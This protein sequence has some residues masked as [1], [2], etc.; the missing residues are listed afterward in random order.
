MQLDCN[1]FQVSTLEHSCRRR[2]SCAV[3]GDEIPGFRIHR[4]IARGGMGVV[5]EAID[6]KTSR[7]VALKIQSGAVDEMTRAR[8][9]REAKVLE[10]LSHPNVVR[11][12]A[13]GELDDGRPWLAMDLLEGET[14][15]ARVERRPCS[16]R[17]ATSWARQTLSALGAAHAAGIVHRDVKPENLFLASRT[18][19]SP[20]LKVIDF[21]IAKQMDHRLTA[22]GEALGSPAYMSPE[23]IA[24]SRSLDPRSDVWSMGVTMFELVTG[25]MPFQ[26]SNVAALLQRISTEPAP[27]ASTKRADVPAWP[28]DIIARCLE[29][30]PEDRFASAADVLSAFPARQE[31]SRTVFVVAMAAVLLVAMGTLAAFAGLGGFTKKSRAPVSLPEPIASV[32]GPPLV[33]E[34]SEPSA[35][36]SVASA[37]VKRPLADVRISCAPAWCQAWAQKNRARLL[38]CMSDLPPMQRPTRIDAFFCPYSS[39]SVGAICNGTSANQFSAVDNCLSRVSV[40]TQ[41]PVA[42]DAG[43]V[44]VHVAYDLP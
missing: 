9:E 39:G 20:T 28:D 41:G 44:T 42:P 12:V 25:A 10:G 11:V 33:V 26:G 19:R 37:P 16:I 40:E 1:Y 13:F 30:K 24:G 2:Q 15:R 4:E 18:D 3:R 34:T 27:R 35:A 43:F 6:E 14:V 36:P 8:F 7:R 32:S 5:Y 31:G 22:T 21:G 29:K 38:A 17:E 23:Q